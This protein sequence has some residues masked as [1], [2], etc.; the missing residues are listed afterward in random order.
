VCRQGAP[1]LPKRRNPACEASQTFGRYTFSLCS[2][3][4]EPRSS[5]AFRQHRGSTTSSGGAVTEIRYLSRD[6]I[7]DSL[8]GSS[9]RLFDQQVGSRG[10]FCTVRLCRFS[11]FG[12]HNQ[13]PLLSI[14][15]TE[16]VACTSVLCGAFF[17]AV[18]KLV[19]GA[20][21]R[22]IPDWCC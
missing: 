8:S 7:A 21:A 11:A 13:L 16:R 12:G 15:V 22:L 9:G 14:L 5:S 10:S 6:S 4:K 17:V 3:S 1:Y 19:I 2:C 18:S 20:C